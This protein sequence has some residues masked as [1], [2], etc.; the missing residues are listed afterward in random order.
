MVNY[1]KIILLIPPKNWEKD[2]E[3]STEANREEESRANMDAK[4]YHVQQVTH[5]ATSV[6]PYKNVL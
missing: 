4:H 5:C 3:S 6:R 1:I 2:N